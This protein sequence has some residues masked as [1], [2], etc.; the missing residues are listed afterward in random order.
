M[1][2][3]ELEQSDGV[4]VVTLNR[5]DALNALDDEMHAELPPSGPGSVPIPR[6]GRS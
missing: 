5:P 2:K 1:A 3:V 4:V 6:R